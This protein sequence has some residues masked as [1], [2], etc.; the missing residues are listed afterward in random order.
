MTLSLIILA[1]ID[2]LLS[3]VSLTLFKGI[4]VIIETTSAIFSSLTVCLFFLH[5]SSQ[6]SCS[7]FSFDSTIFSLS[8]KSAASSYF[9]FFTATF[10]F[11][12]ISDSSDS[13]STICSGT[14][15]LIIWTLDPASSNASIALSGKYLSVIYLDV[16][17]THARRASS[18]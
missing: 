11:D 18:E 2:S 17:F 16:N 9:W 6:I 4:P 14:S 1:K 13:K 3:S 10:F 5:S 12:W 8:L 7:F 15:I